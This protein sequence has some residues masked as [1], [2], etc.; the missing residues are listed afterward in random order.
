MSWKQ[1]AVAAVMG[2]KHISM[3][4][5]EQDI[6]EFKELYEAEFKEIIEWS[7]AERM[8]NELM[9]LYEA[10]WHVMLTAKSSG[11]PEPHNDQPTT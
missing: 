5:N 6:R 9:S 4:L 3:I 1:T 7:E 11:S 8:A 10:I 2:I